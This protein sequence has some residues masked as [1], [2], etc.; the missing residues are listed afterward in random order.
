MILGSGD[1]PPTKEDYKLDSWIPT[2]DLSVQNYYG[3]EKGNDRFF[4]IPYYELSS[5]IWSN[6]ADYFDKNAMN[7]LISTDEFSE[8]IEWLWDLM[9]TYK[10]CPKSTGDSASKNL[11]INIIRL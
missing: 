6:N 4:A 7:S 2:A 1:T 9:Y 10:I 5:A 8:A 11:Q 3:T